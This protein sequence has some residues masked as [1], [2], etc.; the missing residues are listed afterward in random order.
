MNHQDNEFNNE[1]P[2]RQKPEAAGKSGGDLVTMYHAQQSGGE[3]FPVLQAF[4]EYIDAERKQARKRVVQLSVGFAAILGLVVVGF[5]FAGVAMLKNMTD[6]QNRLVEVVAD[7]S[8][9]PYRVEQ[10]PVQQPVQPSASSSS[11]ALEESLREMSRLLVSM[12]EQSDKK[13]IEKPVEKRAPSVNAP[14]PAVEALKAELQAIKE[15]NRR[16]E[17]L[18]AAKPQEPQ[19][20]PDVPKKAAPRGNVVE[21]ALALA[22]KAAADKAAADKA[23][24]A[25]AAAERA[26]KLEEEEQIRRAHLEQERELAMKM[27]AERADAERKRASEKSNLPVMVE[28]PEKQQRVEAKKVVVKYPAPTKNAPQAPAGIKPPEPPENMTAGMVKLKMKDGDDLPWR[29]YVPQ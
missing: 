22:R 25:Q 4:Q 27:A 20:L 28:Q 14:D 10:A 15:Q 9:Q 11:P 18:L 6:M 12:R 7:Q 16:V 24:A 2:P 17:E 21:E 8:R 3:S 13:D 23:A 29:I 5:L 1:V 19:V 26:R